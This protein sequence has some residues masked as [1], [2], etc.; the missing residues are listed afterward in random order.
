MDFVGW[1]WP[2]NAIALKFFASDVLYCEC[3]SDPKQTTLWMY[4]SEGELNFAT[5]L[6]PNWFK[7]AHD[8]QMFLW[9]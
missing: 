7:H 2:F 1:L 5:G 4:V 3:V 6:F 8:L 9:F